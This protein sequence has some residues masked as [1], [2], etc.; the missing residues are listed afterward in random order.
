[1]LDQSLLVCV[2]YLPTG[3]ILKM[4][5][6]ARGVDS[7]GVLQL[8]IIVRGSVP[9][10]PEFTQVYL[11]PYTEDYIQTGLGKGRRT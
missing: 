11:Q 1:M 4:T 8:D 10:L 5:H 3:E 7:Q 2:F 6:V 9:S